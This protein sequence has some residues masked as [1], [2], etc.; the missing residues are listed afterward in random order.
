M[1]NIH[2]YIQCVFLLCFYLGYKQLACVICEAGYKFI[3]EKLDLF[4][5]EFICMKKLLI[6]VCI[7]SNTSS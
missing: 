1:F 4:V 7:I 3:R 6:S 5:V 2:V